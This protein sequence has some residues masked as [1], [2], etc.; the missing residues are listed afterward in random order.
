MRN[1]LRVML[2]LSVILIVFFYFDSSVEENGNLEA[3]ITKDP[4]P[5]EDLEEDP[6]GVDRPV[7]GVSTYIG[8]STDEWLEDYGKPER[9]EPSAFGYEW[10]VYSQSFSNYTM[11]GVKEGRI[12]QVYAAGT[13]VDVA[14]FEIGQ[15]L[16]DIYRFTIVENEITVKYDTSIYTFSLT[17]QDTVS[18]MLVRFDDVYAQLYIDTADD[19]LEAV[20]FTDAETL[21]RHQPY[22][23]MF[24]GELLPVTKPSSMLQKAIDKANAKQIIDLTNVYRLHHQ[25]RAYETS[26]SVSQVAIEHSRNTAMKNMPSSEDMELESLENR[27]ADANIAFEEAAENTASQYYDAMEA[28]HGWINSESH[29]D[30]LLSERFNQI[31]V[32]AFGK[33]YTQI[34]LLQ[35]PKEIDEQ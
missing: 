20:R 17:A 12:V 14:P 31:G 11:V 4:L 13:A 1:L 26:P 9:M 16:D 7:E 3:P 30:S 27:L 21:I 35:E 28:V 29:R 6:L 22:D 24:T 25:Q 8:K 23:L 18:R 15:T 33:Y 34:M 19:V 2:F 5:A 10:W 32:G